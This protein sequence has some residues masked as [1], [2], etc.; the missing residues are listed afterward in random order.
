[1]QP[2]ER[3]VQEI[4]DSLKG[5]NIPVMVKNPINADLQ[6]WIGA[7]ERFNQA[8]V[9]K[10]IAVHRG[11]SVADKLEFRND[12]LWR[13][14]MELKVKF[15]ELPLICDPSH[16]SGDRALLKKVCQ[17]AMDLDMNGLMIETHPN[18]D[19]AWSDASQQVTPDQLSEILKQ[20]A[21]KSEFSRKSTSSSVQKD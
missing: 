15:P 10:L 9:T 5:V 11:F 6:L 20:L 14:P 13:I 12:P 16:I 4:A 1:M 19:K 2:P 3:S 21:L 18:P 17:K 8:G 7:L